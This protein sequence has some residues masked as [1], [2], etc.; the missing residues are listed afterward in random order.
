MHN[1]RIGRDDLLKIEVC[2]C[3]DPVRHD[4]RMLKILICPSGP[5][6]LHPLLG[7]LTL[8]VSLVVTVNVRQEGVAPHAALAD[9]LPHAEVVVTTHLARMTAVTTTVVTEVIDHAAQTIGELTRLC[10]SGKQ[11]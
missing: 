10:T 5:A 8:A 9:L 6:H 2:S 1:K 7:D 11:C 4:E 3:K